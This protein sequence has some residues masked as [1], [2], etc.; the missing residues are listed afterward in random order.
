MD[1]TTAANDGKPASNTTT[2]AQSRLGKLPTELLQSI[3]EHS[4]RSDLPSVACTCPQLCA[5][6]ERYLYHDVTIGSGGLQYG[7]N[8]NDI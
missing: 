6:V 3:V 4:D 1:T 8:E 7:E 2:Y 5:L